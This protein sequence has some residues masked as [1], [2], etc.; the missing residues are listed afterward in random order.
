MEYLEN[1]SSGKNIFKSL[2]EARSQGG[3]A[4]GTS[5]SRLISVNNNKEYQKL[6]RIQN[7]ES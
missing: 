3:L 2:K 1:S 4:L 7:I 6:L 5:I